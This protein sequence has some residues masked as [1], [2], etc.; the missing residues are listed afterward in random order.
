[1]VAPVFNGIA[2]VI[3][4]VCFYPSETQISH[5]IWIFLV[6]IWNASSQT[7]RGQLFT[8]ASPKIETMMLTIWE[9]L[10]ISYGLSLC[11]MRYLLDVDDANY[12]H[13]NHLPLTYSHSMGA[14]MLEYVD[15]PLFT[16]TEK[17]VVVAVMFIPASKGNLQSPEHSMNHEAVV[18]W[19]RSPHYWEFVR[20]N[21]R[22][23]VSS[24]RTSNAVA[25]VF[26]WWQGWIS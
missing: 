1:M 4:Y 10:S 16:V 24:Q 22:S 2:S 13:D 20:V 18:T 26:Q 17:K 9:L 25:L 11:R 15:N 21:H 6:F 8:H 7:H 19:K 12:I 3:L 14:S 23:L 5:Q